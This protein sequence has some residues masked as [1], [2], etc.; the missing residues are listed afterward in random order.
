MG[1]TLQE[2]FTTIRT[3]KGTSLNALSET[4]PVLLVFLRHFGCNFCR[5]AMADVAH[6]RKGIEAGGT[7][8]VLVHMA[9]AETAERFFKRY[10]LDGID[11]IGDPELLLYRAFG[12]ARGTVSQLFGLQNFVRGFK[13]SILDGHGV[14][15][16]IG[17]GF[18]MPGIFVLHK[19]EIKESYIHKNSSDR[20]DYVSLSKCCAIE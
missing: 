13:T 18:Q 20:P 8:I 11:S 17:D 5:E 10:H 3:A 19:G 4:Q 14:G 1:P 2:I 15:A 7:R 12:L 9:D 16:V 6:S